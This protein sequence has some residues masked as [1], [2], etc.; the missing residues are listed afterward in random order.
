MQIG[1]LVWDDIRVIFEL[2]LIITITI[3]SPVLIVSRERTKKSQRTGGFLTGNLSE[4]RNFLNILILT[5]SRTKD[6]SSLVSLLGNITNQKGVA[7]IKL[8]LY[9]KE[10]F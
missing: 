5:L 4:E 2:Y 3:K 8:L 6:H 10:I 1:P 7:A 9:R